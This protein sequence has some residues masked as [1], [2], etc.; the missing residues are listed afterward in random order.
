MQHTLAGKGTALKD[1]VAVRK[2]IVQHI[3]SRGLDPATVGLGDLEDLSRSFYG[4]P[5]CQKHKE[6][7]VKI[8]AALQDI[9]R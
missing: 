2:T 7:R 6:K 5:R 9:K 4:Y 3:E 8:S 1:P